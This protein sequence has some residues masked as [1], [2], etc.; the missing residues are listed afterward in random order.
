M[1]EP[2]SATTQPELFRHWW[3][4]Q[5]PGLEAKLQAWHDEQGHQA[6]DPVNGSCFCCCTACDPGD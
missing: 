2:M 5:T 1:T 6:A 4:S 3:H